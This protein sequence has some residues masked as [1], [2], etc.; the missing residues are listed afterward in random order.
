MTFISLKQ[1]FTTSHLRIEYSCF[2]SY[3]KCNFQRHF[4]VVITSKTLANGIQGF[5]L[6]FKFI[7]HD[8]FS[9]KVIRLQDDRQV[10]R[11]IP[12]LDN[13]MKSKVYTYHS[14]FVIFPSKR[15]TLIRVYLRFIRFSKSRIFRQLL[16]VSSTIRLYGETKKIY[17]NC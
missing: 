6:Q 7:R 11:E 14:K 17:P 10:L 16:Y 3:S 9:Y 5:C 13:I 15:F 1:L 12:D 4:F 8:Y 2:P